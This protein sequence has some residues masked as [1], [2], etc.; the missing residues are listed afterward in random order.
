MI[1]SYAQ[2]LLEGCGTIQP[3][4]L[5]VIGETEP[6][7]FITAFLRDDLAPQQQA[8]ITETLLAVGQ[9]SELQQALETAAGFVA[10]AESER[11]AEKKN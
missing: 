8:A 2:P 10:V 3:G 11:P 6:V 4:D 1:S 9:Q 7:P 5:R